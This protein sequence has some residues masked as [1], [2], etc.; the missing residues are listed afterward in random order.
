MCSEFTRSLYDELA[1]KPIAFPCLNVK[2]VPIGKVQAND[3]NP[4]K[5]ARM[6]LELLADSIEADGLTMPIVVYYDRDADVY[7][8]VD[9]FHRYILLRD[10]FECPEIPVVVIDKPLAERMMSTIR[11]NRARGKHQVDLLAMLV[12]GLVREGK[13]DCEIAEHLGMTDE[14][15]IRLK[16]VVGIARM[17]AAPEYSK[18]WGEND[19]QNA[20]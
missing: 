19:G 8:I 15:L 7:I 10:R 20:G 4:N 1:R 16:Q 6:E 2:L 9:G 13:S 3:Y 14:E 5:V 11:H 12:R 18:S 17:F